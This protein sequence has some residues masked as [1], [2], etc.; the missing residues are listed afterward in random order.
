MGLMLA[1]TLSIGA[2]AMLPTTILI[3]AGMI[4]TAVAYFVD[5]SRERGLGPTVLF[6]NFA[7]I[8]PSLFKLWQHGH[9]VSRALELVL[10]PMNMLVMLL[11]AAFAWLLYMYVPILVSGVLRRN[12]EARIKRI[13]RDQEYLIDQW[14]SLVS[15]GIPAV[16]VASVPES[17]K[18]T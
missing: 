16:G 11:P 12:A 2:V 10:Q 4:P 9:S 13:E 18:S 15:G 5:S 3:M 17:S 1:V 8:M 14:G 6:L 7:G